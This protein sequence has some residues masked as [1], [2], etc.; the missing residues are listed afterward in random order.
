[1]G[2]TAARVRHWTREEYAKM[3]EAGIFAPGERVELVE[4]EII[5]MTPQRSPHAV[6]VSL[7]Y[8]ELRSAFGPG[9]YVRQQLPLA[10]GEESEPEPDAGVVRG[11]PR[12]Y[13]DAHPGTALL[14]VE[15]SEA[16]LEFDRGP[17]ARMY[18]KARIPEYWLL[19]LIERVLEV[20]RDPGP[21]C[22]GS[23]EFSYRQFRRYAP[24]ETVRPLA[25]PGREIRVG[26]LLP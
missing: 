14:V 6:A 12:D 5:Q 20:R 4:G 7:V 1:M 9:S 2:V 8:E 21:A 22:D 10:L 26:D 25:A 19:N 17:K 24:Q 18:A 3:A 23:P 13:V 11:A 16:T 15:V